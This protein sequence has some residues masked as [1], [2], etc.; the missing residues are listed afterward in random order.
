MLFSDPT[1]SGLTDPAM[2]LV[3]GDATVSEIVTWDDEIAAHWD[4]IWRRQPKGLG[5]DPVTR[6]VIRAPGDS[7]RTD[8]F[9]LCHNP[10]QASRDAAVRE[11]LLAQL[12]KLIV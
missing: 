2:V 4:L 11:Q 10:E 5:A 3:Q 6:R 1:G 9:I 12:G 7:V 8:R